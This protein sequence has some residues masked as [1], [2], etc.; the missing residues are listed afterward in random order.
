MRVGI[1]LDGVCYPFEEALRQYLFRIEK[2]TWKSM[3]EPTCWHFYEEWGLSEYQFNDYCHR[4]ANEWGLFERAKPYPGVVDAIR[5]IKDAG[6]TVHIVTA[7]EYGRPG[8]SERQTCR[9][10][11]GWEIPYDTLTFSRDKTVVRTDWYIDD[12]PSNVDSFHHTLT[13]AFLMDQPW[14]QGTLHQRVSNLKEYADMIL[15]A[16]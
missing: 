2:R 4:A 14:N 13:R 15:G 9:W 12:K 7:R 11:R 6:N 3:P 16:A 1:D 10:L 5:R 8:D